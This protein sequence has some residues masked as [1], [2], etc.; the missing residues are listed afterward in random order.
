MP[1]FLAP[2]VKVF[3]NLGFGQVLAILGLIGYAIFT[4]FTKMGSSEIDPN[5]R[6]S[7]RVF[8]IVVM[9]LGFVIALIS[10]L[11]IDPPLPPPPPPSDSLVTA[12]EWIDYEADS[13]RINRS[14][15]TCKYGFNLSLSHLR[16]LD[17]GYRETQSPAIKK[18]GLELKI[19]ILDIEKKCR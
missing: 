16:V 18:E 8:C 12:Q 11:K 13:I 4:S 1:Y 7:M 15:F 9:V 3:A 10:E 5:S 17:K 2:L 6:K 19:E 14:G